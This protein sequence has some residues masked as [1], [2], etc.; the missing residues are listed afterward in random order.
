MTT[1]GD[2][3]LPVSDLE[4]P[5][6]ATAPR[7][8]GVGIAVLLVAA[9]VSAVLVGGDERS[10]AER[11]AAAPVAVSEEPFAF[12]IDFEGTAPGLPMKVAFSMVGA[13]DP[14]TKRTKAEMD[15]SSLFPGGIGAPGKLS[16]V[17]E[18]T[19]AYVLVPGAAG[20]APQW[21]KVDGAQLTSGATGGL[22]SSTNPLDSFDQLRAVDAEIEEV[23]EEDV[24]GT[25]TTHFRTRLDLRK[26]LDQLPEG[27]RPQAGSP[28]ESALQA[29][30]D[31]P[32]E[33]WLDDQD[34][35]R[36]QKMTFELPGEAGQSAGSMTI[37]I[38][39]FDFGNPVVIELPP[40]DQVVDGTG[41]LGRPPS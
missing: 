30:D 26:L 2:D 7:A 21:T 40:A 28:A 16:L 1:P 29:M 23:G 11:L 24:R 19:D 25:S 4:P 15:L 32:V 36:R 12:E 9:I 14:A 33:V 6:P 3:L 17:S 39:A 35:P 8:L 10:A 18:G 38:E 5:R 31:V 41:L 27:R 22:P 20:G 37:T 13:V 34:R